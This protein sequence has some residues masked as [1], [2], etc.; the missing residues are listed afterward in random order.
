MHPWLRG[1]QAARPVTQAD[2]SALL[3]VGLG[4]LFIELTSRCNERCIHCYADS[5]PERQEM[6]PAALVRQAIDQAFELGRPFIQ[7]TGGDPLIHPDL[8]ELTAHAHS[9]AGPGIEI[10]TNGLLLQAPLLAELA[11]FA[12]RFCFSLYSSQPGVHDAITQVPGSLQRTLAAIRR[13]QAADME[14]RIGIALME[15]NGATLQSTL[16]FLHHDLGILPE[17]IRID[18]VH[19]TGR[20]QQ[21]RPAAGIRIA[22]QASPHNPADP[23]ANGRTGKLC[24][25]ANGDVHPCIFSR[26][27][28]LGNLNRA[29]LQEMLQHL[30]KRRPTHGQERPADLSCHD[31]RMIAS[32]LGA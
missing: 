9:K 25:T 6:L 3:G 23:A 5:S 18:P 19:A 21:V 20:G 26:R 10:Y 22:H 17:H 11:P 4:M 14:I 12:P 15:E 2:A 32:L 31:C 24:V 16:D 7:F 8:V 29:S 28:L 30:S 13:A 27:I 1:L